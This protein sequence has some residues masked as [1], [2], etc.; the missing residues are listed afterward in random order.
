MI[1]FKDMDTK[2]HIM[3]NCYANLWTGWF[4]T[5]ISCGMVMIIDHIL[6]ARNIWIHQQHLMNVLNEEGLIA[7]QIYCGCKFLSYVV[8]LLTAG[9][10]IIL[11]IITTDDASL[12]NNVLI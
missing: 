4:R 6:C 5:I 11:F 9:L 2:S 1:Y 10:Y 3:F 7:K 8:N 12:M